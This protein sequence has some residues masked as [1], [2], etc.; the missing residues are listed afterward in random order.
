LLIAE[1]IYRVWSLL[2]GHPYHRQLGRC[3]QRDAVSNKPQ[4]TPFMR[5]PITLKNHHQE[6]RI[7]AF[8]LLW[9]AAVVVLCVALLLGRLFWLQSVE[10]EKYT[11]LS[12]KI[13]VQ[14]IAIAP[15]RG[16]IYDRKG[17]LLADNLADFSLSVVPEQVQDVASL[18]DD[19]DIWVELRDSDIERFQRRLNSPRRP[20]EPVPLKARLS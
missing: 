6:Q 16:L 7:V 14:S 10:H 11:T 13:R 5:S 1:Q 15:P 9:S 20:W 4:K 18:L 2:Q 8:R 3:P 17:R 19:I 12:N